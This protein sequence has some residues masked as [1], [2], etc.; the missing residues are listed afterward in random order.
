M[1]RSVVVPVLCLSVVGCM[2]SSNGNESGSVPYVVAS[3]GLQVGIESQQTRV[4]RNSSEYSAL[5]SGIQL[6]GEKPNPDFGQK[7]VVAVFSTLNSC[8]SLSVDSVVETEIS[9]EVRVA[10]SR[11]ADACLPVIGQNYVFVESA[12]SSKEVSVIYRKADNGL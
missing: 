9:I 4:F 3:S 5:M 8:Y 12:R 11:L 7:L 1:F 6:G 2:E 10:V